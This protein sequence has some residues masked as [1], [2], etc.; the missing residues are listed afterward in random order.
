M[1]LT[2]PGLLAALTKTGRP[3]FQC[4]KGTRKMHEL[5]HHVG[6]YAFLV[7][8]LYAAWFFVEFVRDMTH[9][10]SR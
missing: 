6:L 2:L 9:R 1:A 10:H 3:C 4:F 7:V 5:S 8:A